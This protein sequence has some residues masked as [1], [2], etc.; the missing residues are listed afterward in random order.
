MIMFY[1]LF[2]FKHVD[3]VDN[4]LGEED[5]PHFSETHPHPNFIPQSALRH[6]LSRSI[7]LDAQDAMHMSSISPFEKVITYRFSTV[8]FQ[9]IHNTVYN[10]R[11]NFVLPFLAI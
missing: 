4:V 6:S 2:F 11:S 7:R 10:T 1:H 3:K 8:L 5:S 9:V